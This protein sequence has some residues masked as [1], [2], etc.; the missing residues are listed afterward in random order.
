MRHTSAESVPVRAG[1]IVAIQTQSACALPAATRLQSPG[2]LLAIAPFLRGNCQFVKAYH[3]RLALALLTA[4]LTEL[5]PA[6]ILYG[7][8]GFVGLG[9]DKTTFPSQRSL[10]LDQS[11]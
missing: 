6:D 9:L 1:G 11:S 8:A 7:L 10:L 4:I 3:P 2:Y 5:A